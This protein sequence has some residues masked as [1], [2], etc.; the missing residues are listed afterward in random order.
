MDENKHQ[1]RLARDRLRKLEKRI[2]KEILDRKND[3]T[4]LADEYRKLRLA[5]KKRKDID[6]DMCH[7][8]R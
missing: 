4:F 2:K 3:Q 1:Q 5:G 8:W 7:I 6:Y